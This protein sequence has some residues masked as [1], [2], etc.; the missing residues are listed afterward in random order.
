MKNSHELSLRRAEESVLKI[1]DDVKNAPSRQSYHF[2]PPAYWMN[3]PNGVIFFEGKYHLFYQFHPYA[4]VWGPMHWGHAVSSDLL[5][6]EHLPIALAPSETYDTDERG[7]CFSGS[8]VYENGILSLMY[9]GAVRVNGEYVQTQCLAQSKDAVH[10]EKYEGNP[11][12]KKP[13]WVDSTDFRDP[14]VFKHDD[15]WYMLVGAKDKDKGKALLYRSYDLKSWEF[16]SVLA[17]SRGELGFMWECPDFFEIN[18]KYVLFISPMGVSDRKTVYLIGDMNFNTG[19][20]NYH[21]I[22]EIDWGFDYYAPQTLL[23]DKDQRIVVAWANEWDWMPWFNGFGPTNKDN[24]CGSLALPRTVEL[25][26]D[27]RLKFKPID[28]LKDLR[29]LARE[30]SKSLVTQK[31]SLEIQA[32]D[33]IHCELKI[34]IDLAKTTSDI[35]E[36]VLRASEKYQTVITCNLK[37]GEIYFDRNNSDGISTGIRRCPLL[38]VNKNELMVH[39]YMDTCSV[40][41]FTDDYITVLSSNIYPPNDSNKIFVKAVNGDAAIKSIHTWGL[42]SVW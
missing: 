19:K 31:N 25:V 22:G 36:I 4:P 1:K 11:V 39:I 18:G 9:T 42:K 41:V 8:A 29:T 16:F 40:E 5:H 27:S 37:T 2:M 26:R 38:L 7:G 3:D 15:V 30:Y 35:I 23:N 6:W 13:D 28:Q 34:I 12:V 24:W 33:N 20:F 10:F 21:S 32:G 17:E 14:K